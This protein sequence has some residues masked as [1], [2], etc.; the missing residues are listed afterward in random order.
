MMVFRSP[1]Q[2]HAESEMTSPHVKP[3]IIDIS[4][5]ARHVSAPPAPPYKLHAEPAKDPKGPRAG[6]GCQGRGSARGMAADA[7]G[8]AAGELQPATPH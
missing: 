8:M 1:R 7:R 6:S 2:T 4:C 5:N 3:I